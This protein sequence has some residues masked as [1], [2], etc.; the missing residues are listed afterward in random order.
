M[1]LKTLML[2]LSWLLGLFTMYGQVKEKVHP[3]FR[4]IVY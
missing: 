2:T 4:V 3:T 1:K